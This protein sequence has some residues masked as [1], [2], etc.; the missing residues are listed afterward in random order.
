MHLK[1]SDLK[2]TGS[3]VYNNEGELCQVVKGGPRWFSDRGNVSGG[4]RVG[5]LVSQCG[6]G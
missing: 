5:P 4:G 6:H 3:S 1:V 2:P